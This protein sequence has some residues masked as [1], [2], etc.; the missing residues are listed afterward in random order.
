MRLVILERE[1]AFAGIKR[2]ET[3]N[4]NRAKTFKMIEGSETGTHDHT[5]VCTSKC[6]LKKCS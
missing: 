5:G 4:F 2:S 1:R 6:C 3:C